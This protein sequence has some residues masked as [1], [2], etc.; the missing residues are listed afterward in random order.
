[1]KLKLNDVSTMEFFTNTKN[2]MKYALVNNT[3]Y[4]ITN[5]GDFFLVTDESHLN[6]LSLAGVKAMRTFTKEDRYAR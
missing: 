1:M 4:L 3:W 2:N 5:N 6:A